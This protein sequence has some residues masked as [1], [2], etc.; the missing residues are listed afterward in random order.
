[1]KCF[2]EYVGGSRQ[3]YHQR[4]LRQEKEEQ[5]M[6][7]IESEV[8]VYREKKDRRAGSRSLYY[9]LNIKGKY[10]L[11]INKFERLMSTYGMTL[12]PLRLRVVTT[13]STM[14]SWNY[15]N[16]AK[17]L[18]INNINQLVVGDL[19]Y[20]S[21]GKERYYLFCLTDA[22]SARLVGYSLNKRM[23]AQEAKEAFDMWV[24]L[25]GKSRLQ[26]CIHHTDGGNQYFSKL[27][28]E[29]MITEQLQISVAKTCIENGYAEQRNGLIK[30]HL[31]PTL[32]MKNGVGLSREIK[33]IFNF[34]NEER[35]QRKLGW[36]SPKEYEQQIAQQDH[37][38]RKQLHKGK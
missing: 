16:L 31:L 35:K 26:R 22:Y 28:L 7:S 17:G 15:S 5:M 32:R 38:E 19:T 2:Y 14:Q 20:L 33:R 36:R 25:R 34:Y 21:I 3:R 12:I 23:R 30:H 8:M 13:Q 9:N 18:I 29:S 27:Y 4:E 1:M 37:N 24:L 11:G 10:G 6:G